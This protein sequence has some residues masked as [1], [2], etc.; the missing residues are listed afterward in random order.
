MLGDQSVATNA[1]K[2]I[3][4][5][6]HE[7]T[8]LLLIV[9][10][11]VVLMSSVRSSRPV[12][13]RA[14][15]CEMIFIVGRFLIENRWVVPA[16]K[17]DVGFG[18]EMVGEE[19]AAIPENDL[20]NARLAAVAP[21]HGVRLEERREGETACAQETKNAGQFHQPLVPFDTGKNIH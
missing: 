11:M 15:A 12:M 20:E 19:L 16:V 7:V 21:K 17:I 18:H 5:R 9:F 2:Q 8:F 14:A 3:A 6:S 4:G 1:F 10:V 13:I